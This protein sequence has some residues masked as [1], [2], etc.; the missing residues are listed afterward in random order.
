MNI[1]SRKLRSFSVVAVGLIGCF[2]VAPFTALGQFGLGGIVHDPINY[3]ALGQIIHSNA[4]S[5]AKTIALYNETVRIYNTSTQMYNHAQMMAHMFSS[6]ERMQ[7][8]AAVMPVVNDYTQDRYG[9]TVNWQVMMGGAPGLARGAWA[10]VGIPVRA[11]TRRSSDVDVWRKDATRLAFV[12]QVDGSAGKCLETLAGYR[13]NSVRNGSALQKLIGTIV[14]D[15]PGANSMIQQLN[16]ANSAQGQALTEARSQGAIQACLAEQQI[17]A[18]KIQR[19]E[20]ADQLNYQASV[21]ALS[22]PTWTGAAETLQGFRLG[23]PSN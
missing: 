6:G 12:E 2:A 8:M 23:N 1:Q 14:S 5:L 11:T 10:Q 15:L 16:L 9:E 17:L 7:W 21:A 13:Q 4:S 18:N 20:I 19:D 3:G 22:R